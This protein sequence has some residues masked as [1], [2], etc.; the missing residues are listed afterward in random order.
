MSLTPAISLWQPWGTALFID[1]KP[2]VPLK[3]DETRHWALP[4]KH[5]GR[6]FAIH[7][8]M[9]DTRAERNTWTDADPVHIDAFRRA[10]FASYE[11]LPRG[12]LIGTVV[13]HRC[14]LTQDASIGWADDGFEW[15]NYEPGRFAW[16]TINR[17]LFKT[18]VPCVGRQ[19][20]FN[21]DIGGVEY[22]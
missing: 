6:T 10:G 17:R 16:G 19:G 4:E 12:C 15:G 9:R 2:G 18:P 14:V 7:A 11:A 20:I 22:A 8:A 3:P 5:V 21:V 13:F 1:L